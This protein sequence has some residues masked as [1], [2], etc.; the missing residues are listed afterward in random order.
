MQNERDS[1][2]ARVQAIP[3]DLRDRRPDP[4][5]WS[6]AEVLEHLVRVETGLTKL[7]TLRGQA[8]PP[9]DTPI[10]DESSIYTPALAALVRDRSKRIEAPERVHPSGMSFD[11]AIAHLATA[12]A[13]LLSA[14]SSG[15]ADALDRVTHP[16]PVFGFLTLRSWMALLVDHDVRHSDQV[17][18]IAAQLRVGSGNR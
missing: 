15:H 9:D 11:D 10:P 18:E 7:L 4:S 5:R 14:F 16:H 12:R 1:L 13:G 2:V 3:A 6:I 8:A 17:G